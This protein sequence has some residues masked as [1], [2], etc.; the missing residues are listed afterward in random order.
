MR[1]KRAS[2]K[3]AASN[4]RR[5]QSTKRG[6]EK[7]KAL[8]D[9]GSDDEGSDMDDAQE[10]PPPAETSSA[11]GTK[12]VA[13]ETDADYKDEEEPDEEADDPQTEGDVEEL[14][15]KVS[16]DLDLI[17]EHF[18]EWMKA[19]FSTVGECDLV[20][21]YIGALNAAMGGGG[22]I[23]FVRKF[24]TEAHKAK[25]S[26][27]FI[28]FTTALSN[29]QDLLDS[30]VNVSYSKKGR[31]IPFKSGDPGKTSGNR[32]AL[33]FVY[34]H[35][36]TKAPT[37]AEPLLEV[38]ATDSAE[39]AI[40]YVYGTHA[41]TKFA[42]LG[43]GMLKAGLTIQTYIEGKFGQNGNRITND[44]MFCPKYMAIAS[45]E[46][47]SLDSQLQTVGRAFVDLRERKR[48]ENWFIE[49]L[50]VPNRVETLQSYSAMEDRFADAGRDNNQ[51]PLFMILKTA[52]KARFLGS[53][54]SYDS[55]GFIGTR[56]G[57]FSHLLGLTPDAA[58]K[59][60]K[61]VQDALER[62]DG[63]VKLADA[64]LADADAGQDTDAGEDEAHAAD[65]TTMEQK[66]ADVEGQGGPSGSMVGNG[67]AQ[68]EDQ[69]GVAK[70]AGTPMEMADNGST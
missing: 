9:G 24:S 47:A 4:K 3:Q 65:S 44:R 50:A 19:T 25:T 62:S 68:A 7:K 70:D 63:D 10:A 20:P 32:S 18:N 66:T 5:A 22:M 45:P 51:Q 42:V 34:N 15:G 36:T 41:I 56:R 12:P 33:C 64:M 67:M 43:Y 14:L 1:G 26:C 11:Q 59:A 28:L 17:T 48:P 69:S 55:L 35:S 37:D 21:V 38:F 2:Q 54:D 8:D 6:S 29:W 57:Q 61:K 39:N 16:M 46:S 27:A 40:Q 52:F 60:V 58:K 53:L 49:L 31:A 13:K 23:S 30:K